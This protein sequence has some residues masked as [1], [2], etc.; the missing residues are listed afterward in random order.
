[1]FLAPFVFLDKGDVYYPSDMATHLAST[2]PAIN[3][4]RLDGAPESL[5]LSN[6]DMLNEMGGKDVYLTSSSPLIKMPS[7]LNGQKPNPKTLQTE[8]AISCVVI[9]VDKGVGVVDAF[10]MYFY[11]FNDGPSALGHKVGNHLGDC[12]LPANFSAEMLTKYQGS[13]I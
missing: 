13:T 6:L 12:M 8:N 10:Y 4:T 7:F 11:T 5:T 3:F 9:V 2:Y 1:M